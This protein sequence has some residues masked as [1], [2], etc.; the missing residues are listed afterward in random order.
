MAR[1]VVCVGGVA[2]SVLV[3]AW[4]ASRA[5][6]SHGGLP[7]GLNVGG[8]RVLDFVARGLVF[9]VVLLVVG[10]ACGAGGAAAASLSWSS[11]WPADP[12]AVPAGH[13]T[14]FSAVSCT[15]SGS[16][17]AIDANGRVYSSGDPARGAGAWRLTAQ[18][19]PA[20][21]VS[22]PDVSLCVAVGSGGEV[23]VSTDPAA[24]AWASARSA[25]WP[26]VHAPA[27]G[28]VAT[29]TSAT[30][31]VR[32]AQDTSGHDTAEA[33]ILC[34]VRRH[35]PAPEPATPSYT[36]VRWRRSR[37]TSQKACTEPR[38]TPSSAPPDRRRI[39]RPRAKRTQRRAAAQPP[40]RGTH[41]QQHHHKHQTPR[42]E[43]EH[44][45]PPTL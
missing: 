10:A 5:A 22:C 15:P 13:W 16:C 43:I 38:K 9:V 3:R 26:D 41:H 35:A 25:M 45:S 6:A 30:G 23:A 31:S 14:A 8:S 11:P 40:P 1:R 33:G 7:R 18:R 36:H 34:A 12:P 20:S 39:G 28:S 17:V 37:Q 27:A 19:I 24:G 4:A 44:A 21:A 2:L 32:D 42:H 29:A